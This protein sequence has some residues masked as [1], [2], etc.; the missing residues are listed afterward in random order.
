MSFTGDYKSAKN[1]LINIARVVLFAHK[2][3]AIKELEH[4]LELLPKY[5]KEG[6]INPIH[7]ERAIKKRIATLKRGRTL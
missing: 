5:H 3:G 4:W 2:S 1:L 7:F 6:K